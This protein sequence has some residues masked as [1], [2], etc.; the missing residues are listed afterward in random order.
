MSSKLEKLLTIL[1]NN[2]I[3][4]LIVLGAII[5]VSFGAGY[6]Y[7]LKID[8]EKEA[9]ILFD[10]AWRKLYTVVND[11]QSQPNQR[12]SPGH[13][14]IPSV[15]KLYNE[16]LVDLDV[17][18]S[19]YTS[20]IS[21]AKSAILI[22]TVITLSNLN[23]LLDD[24]T[25]ITTFKANDYLDIV[26][27]KHSNFWGAIISMIDGI[28]AEKTIDFSAALKHYENALKLDKK[29]YLRDYIIISIARSHDVLNNTDKAIEY[30]KKIEI[31]YPES[32]WLSFAMGKAYLLSQSKS[33]ATEVTNSEISV[34]A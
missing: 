25:L 29:K 14:N 2:R 21:A 11:L 18:V 5:L 9:S 26:R 17:L 10:D 22:K 19:E 3:I 8:Q 27:K 16:V 4:V 20:T 7:Q 32:V 30:Y 24:Q 23:I 15:K 33:N 34:Q 28:E 6:M 1:I 13:A 12:Y 31:E